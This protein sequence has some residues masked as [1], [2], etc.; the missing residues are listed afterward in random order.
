MLSKT[1]V[2]EDFNGKEHEDVYLFNL[3][4]SEVAQMEL[5][6][7]GGMTDM[8]NR[9]VKAEDGEKITQLVVDL[10]LKSYGEKSPDGFRFVK[11]AELS[12]AFSETGA[13]DALFMELLTD[14]EKAAVFVEGVLPK[15]VNLPPK[16]NL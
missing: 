13:Y 9:I 2:Y 5:S 10:I 11:S 6:T 1:I 14:P 15:P 16:S 4:K 12:K 3:S 7:T 8:I